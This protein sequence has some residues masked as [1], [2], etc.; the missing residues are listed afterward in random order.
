M[1]GF[2]VKVVQDGSRLVVTNPADIMMLL[3][4]LV[5]TI[6]PLANYVV[7]RPLPTTKVVVFSMI[8]LFFYGNFI[9]CTRL[10][11]DNQA[12]TATIQ[13]FKWFHWKTRELPSSHL[14]YA[15][16]AT[17]RA[18]D[19]IVL[20]FENGNTQTFSISNQMGGKPAAVLAINRYLG[21]SS[22]S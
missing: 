19:R 20:Q 9:D 3:L 4:F 10:T 16:L 11:L 13:Q 18:S 2:H 12:Q 6:W 1:F 21:R 5:F 17:G 14:A 15:Y 8:T 22:G 7:A